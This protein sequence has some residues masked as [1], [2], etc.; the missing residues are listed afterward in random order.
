MALVVVKKLELQDFEKW[1]QS[2]VRGYS[3]PKEVPPYRILSGQP[4]KFDALRGWQL[5]FT[6]NLDPT[7]STH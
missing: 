1:I 5:L 4:V 6:N 2:E 3:D 7:V